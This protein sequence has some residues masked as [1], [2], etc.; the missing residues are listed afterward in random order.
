MSPALI[1]R[2]LGV[3]RDANQAG[4]GG[5][6]AVYAA[7]CAELGMSLTQLHRKLKEISVRPTRK[8]RDDCGSTA[9]SHAEASL[10]SGVL[11]ESARKNGKRLF[12]I[13]KAVQ[14]LRANGKVKAEAIDQET[15][16]IRPL[17]DSAIG[18][19][20]R[21]YG[22]HPEQLLAPPPAISLASKH[23][24]HVWQL[25]ASLCV[26]YYLNPT[27]ATAKPTTS[28]QVMD[29]A[30]FY[31]NKPGN[32]A[33]IE[34]QRVWRYV[35]T[36]HASGWVYVEY[37]FGGETGENLC[38]IFINAMQQRH[39]EDPVHGVPVMVMLDPGSANTGAV[40]KNLCR[41][42]DVK[43]QI[44]KPGNPRA[45]GQVE[46]AQ[47]LV[48][49]EFESGL[50]FVAVNSLE[51]L[52]AVAARWMRYFNGTAIHSRHGMTR[53]NAWLTITPQQLIKAPSVAVCR[54][55]AVAAPVERKVSVQLAVNF[56]GKLFDVS[57]VPNVR[58]GEKLLITRNPWREDAAQVVLVGADGRDYC[59]SIPVIIENQ[60]GFR[61][62]AALIGEQHK[63][64]ADTPAQTALKQIEQLVT[65]THT[66][67]E[68]ASARKAKALP[69]NGEFDPFKV[70]NETD[71]PTYIPRA[72]QQHELVTRS[73]TEPPLS[74]FEAARLLKPLVEARGGSWSTAQV[75]W[76]QQRY[77]EGVL[78]SRL[79]E[80]VLEITAT[81]PKTPLRVVG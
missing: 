52:N 40:F 25:D 77:P 49:R 33:K 71:L 41:S 55:L 36:D 21:G 29:Q 19:A 66:Q 16:E 70:M 10:I 76:L 9:L 42:L 20:L 7:A 44:N 28:L 45:K 62:D 73:V 65:G 12:S 79:P 8:R 61:E 75:L 14:E 6:G 3:A 32:V 15:G 48:E 56:V 17:S 68:A 23:P 37:V 27:A 13:Q 24:N 74:H 34:P 64:H 59:H 43:V 58:V 4:H 50:K 81:E 60:L 63:S 35:V 30:V 2:L 22:L 67:E 38:T 46:Q 18:R 51:E 1:E 47:N 11:M 80:M 69:F 54:E 5:K 72:G 78:A 53:Y 57:G 39:P 26:L 31:K